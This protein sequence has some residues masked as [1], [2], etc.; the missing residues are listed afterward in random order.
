MPI[1]Y[2]CI[3]SIIVATKASLTLLSLISPTTILASK[4]AS[5]QK[6]LARLLVNSNLEQEPISSSILFPSPFYQ[7]T[8]F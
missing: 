3:P 1:P 2:Y 5:A 4:L 6:K 7:T 8:T